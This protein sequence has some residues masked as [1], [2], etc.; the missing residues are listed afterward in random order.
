MAQPSEA[1]RVAILAMI[2]AQSQAWNAGDAV[3]FGERALPDI[4]FTNI[5]GLFSV[6]AEPFEAQHAH[7]FATIYQGS[8]MVQR[9]ERVT[10][11]SDDVA[12]VDT[13]AAVTGYRRLPPGVEPIDGALTTRLEQVIVRRDG[14]WWMQAFHNVPVNPAAATV[15][16]PGG[17]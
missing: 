9:L 2:D 17:G 1:D 14:G 10:M 11:A 4:V 5:V 6:G 13:L 12:I 8:R 3:A 7:I 16:R 15:A